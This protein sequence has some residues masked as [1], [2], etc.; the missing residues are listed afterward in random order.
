[1]GNFGEEREC[2]LTAANKTA[3]P[4]SGDATGSTLNTV[5]SG[6]CIK[7]KKRSRC[8]QTVSSFAVS[9][10]GILSG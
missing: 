7:K 3:I 4:L 8:H 5:I 10:W 2:Y 6:V 9:V 1:M